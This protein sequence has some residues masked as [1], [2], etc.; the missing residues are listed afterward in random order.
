MPKFIHAADLHLGSPLQGLSV[1]DPALLSRFRGATRQA[2]TNLVELALER[3]VDLLLVAGDLF[4]GDWKD[5]STGLFFIREMSRLAS[6]GIEIVL[7][8]GNHDA[9]S[10]ITRELR[11]PA[12]VRW[13]STERPES[14]DFPRLGLA[15][16]GQSFAERAVAE[17]LARDYPAPLAGRFNIGMLHTSLEGATEHARYAPTSLA[18]LCQRGYDYW[19]LGHI[20]ARRVLCEAPY[21]VFPGNLQGRH[22]RETG[23]KGATLVTVEGQRVVALE[24]LCCDA[25]RWVTLELDLTGVEQLG[26]LDQRWVDA[27]ESATRE[28]AGR[29]LA[30]RA[31]L[32]GTTSL[33]SSLLARHGAALDS[34]GQYLEQLSAHLP[35]PHCIEKVK[36]LTRLPSESAGLSAG[37]LGE[38]R[39]M[40]EQ[41]QQDPEL[42]SALQKEL[43]GLGP[44]LPHELLDNAR[45]GQAREFT[46]PT[47]RVDALL[48]EASEAIFAQLLG[49]AN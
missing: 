16:H 19:A 31:Q 45:S 6:A 15:V 40:L 37:L 1:R 32:T 14:L 49:G 29:P 3:R 10:V 34:L 24:E 13:L 47:E 21:V 35:A 46:A 23:G 4:D 30:I 17:N 11:L 12:G 28:A 33:H 26:E 39:S 44:F 9:Q 20:H 38:L 2:L 43:A 42:C 25:A 27:V 8:R 7:L 41:A 18:D 36:L 5:Q 22:P 48:A